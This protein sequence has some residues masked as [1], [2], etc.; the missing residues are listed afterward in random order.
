MTMTLRIAT[1]SLLLLAVTMGSG[2]LVGCSSDPSD[3]TGS[4]FTGAGSGCVDG[5]GDSHNDGDY[6]CQGGIGGSGIQ[7]CDSGT[8]VEAATCDC[9]VSVGDP[10]K[11]PYATSCSYGST[12]TSRACEYAGVWCVRCQ[13]GQACEFN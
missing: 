6:V 5:S 1:R 12:S 10:R 9:G 8:W 4:S 7:R 11:P 3:T 2:S 13:N